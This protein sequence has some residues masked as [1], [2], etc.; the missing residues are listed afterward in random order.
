[1]RDRETVR[2]ERDRETDRETVRQVRNRGTLETGERQGDR[3]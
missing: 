3:R 2:Q 1:M